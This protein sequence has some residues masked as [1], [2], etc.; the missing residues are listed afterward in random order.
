MTAF[1]PLPLPGICIRHRSR[2]AIIVGLNISSLRFCFR[3]HVS[4]WGFLLGT[5]FNNCHIVVMTT[6][7]TITV[8]QF[9]EILSI[10]RSSMDAEDKLIQCMCVLTGKTER[11]VEDMTLPEFNKK[12]AE[13]A[14]IFSQ[15]FPDQKPPRYMTIAG[16]MYGITYNPR[17][18]AWHQYVEIQTWI[19]Q[20][21]IANMHKIVASLVYPVSGVLKRKG[22]NDPAKHPEIAEGVLDCRYLDVHSIAVFFSLLWNN[23]IKALAHSLTSR[24]EKMTTK[25]KEAI[26]TLLTSVS[27]GSIIPG[28]SQ[29]S[30]E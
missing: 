24:K 13:L 26:R 6:L 8:R 1:V 12:G 7:Q 30:N 29:S 9:Q 23:S 25:E 10:Q 21:M 18:L 5:I 17:N 2:R 20:N 27:D 3:P 15:N 11:E 16:K 19:G 22:K 14:K 28:R 4:T